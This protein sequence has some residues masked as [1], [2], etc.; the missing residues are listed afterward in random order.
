MFKRNVREDLRSWNY[1][2]EVEK[3]LRKRCWE[4]A[5]KSVALFDCIWLQTVLG[6]FDFAA[7]N[8]FILLNE[9]ALELK[10]PAPSVM[11]TLRVQGTQSCSFEPDGRVGGVGGWLLVTQTS[12][13]PFSAV[14]SR[15]FAIE[16]S[17]W[18][19][20]RGL[21][22]LH[23]FAPLK[24]PRLQFFQKRCCTNTCIILSKCWSMFLNF[25]QHQIWTSGEIENDRF[26]F[27]DIWMEIGR[28][29]GKSQ[30]F[31]GSRC[32][33]Q[34]FSEIVKKLLEILYYHIIIYYYIT[35]R[36][37]IWLYERT[38][39]SVEKREGWQVACKMDPWVVNAT[40]ETAQARSISRC[41]R[42]SHGRPASSKA[43]ACLPRSW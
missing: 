28:N 21:Q 43:T 16:S 40:K 31:A 14:S 12:E 5:K 38:N 17:F 8:L 4:T 15:I 1:V 29:C 18:S 24:I 20:F 30:T 19:S 3:N 22:F 13:G 36:W 9:F 34:T 6:L 41:I 35:N 39:E 32:T 10:G 26:F 25:T 23:G 27:V 42:T 37:K 2:W 33:L 11:S 7:K